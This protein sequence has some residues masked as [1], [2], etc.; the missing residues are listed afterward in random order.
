LQ[1]KKVRYRKAVRF[2][3]CASAYALMF[4]CLKGVRSLLVKW[5]SKRP[6]EVI[7]DYMIGD[8]VESLMALRYQLEGSS[9][10]LVAFVRRMLFTRRSP[11]HHR[12][13]EH[14]QETHT[15]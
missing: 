6:L 5:S 14:W 15:V 3:A 10:S 9:T 13:I 11:A 12:L 8:R 2:E 4:R 1:K 7:K